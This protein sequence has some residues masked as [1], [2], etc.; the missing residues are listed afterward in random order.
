MAEVV[1]KDLAITA[2]TTS[3]LQPHL[4]D[5]RACPHLPRPRHSFMS[6][7]KLHICAEVL[8]PERKTC[9]P[10]T[11]E[12]YNK[13]VYIYLERTGRLATRGATCEIPA[14]REQS[15]LGRLPCISFALLMHS[16]PVIAQQIILSKRYSMLLML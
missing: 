11:G 6:L 8:H 16:L 7:E 13:L 2:T 10:V 14:A 4:Q 9:C 15:M 5:Y 1:S 12:V 3:A